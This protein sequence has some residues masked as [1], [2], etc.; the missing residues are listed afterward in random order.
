[1]GTV[2]DKP[3]VVRVHA[4]L[5]ILAAFSRIVAA[6]ALSANLLVVGIIVKDCVIAILDWHGS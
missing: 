2:L 3:A 6:K 4:S 1:M 5:S